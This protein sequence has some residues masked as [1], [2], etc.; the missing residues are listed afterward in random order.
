MLRS[1]YLYSFVKDW[2]PVQSPGRNHGP[3]RCTCRSS[4]CLF[5]KD[6]LLVW[7]P[8]RGHGPPYFV[9]SDGLTVRSPGLGLGLHLR[10]CYK[11]SRYKWWSHRVSESSLRFTKPVAYCC[12]FSRIL[13]V[14]DPRWF[15]ERFLVMLRIFHN[16]GYIFASTNLRYKWHVVFKISTEIQACIRCM[17]NSIVPRCKSC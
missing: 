10:C 11:F 1:V 16:H 5:V 2:F 12:Q 9:T 6:W 15:L 14:R 17:V 8:R 7:S 4:Y 13:F 3:N